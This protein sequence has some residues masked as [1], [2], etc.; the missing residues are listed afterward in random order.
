MLKEVKE[1]RRCFFVVFFTWSPRRI[2]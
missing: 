2:C 1:R